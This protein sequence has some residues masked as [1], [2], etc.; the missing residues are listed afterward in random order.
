MSCTKHLP[1][2]H[3]SLHLHF[4]TFLSNFLHKRLDKCISH[5]YSYSAKILNCMIYN[6][7]L[8]KLL[9]NKHGFHHLHSRVILLNS[10]NTRVL[11]EIYVVIFWRAFPF[12]FIQNI[13]ET[14]WRSLFLGTIRE[15]CLY[16]SHTALVA[17]LPL[18]ASG[19]SGSAGRKAGELPRGS[20]PGLGA[21]VW[22]LGAGAGGLGLGLGPGVPWPRR[23]LLPPA[24]ACPWVLPRRRPGKFGRFSSSSDTSEVWGG[25]LVMRSCAKC[26]NRAPKHAA[27]ASLG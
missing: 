3:P 6:M 21:W 15:G 13:H 27:G 16:P 2:S 18:K 12:C 9:A 8:N 11:C 4:P 17:A 10:L 5:R 14:S 20:G 24:A 19:S 25:M 22:G 7:I 1:S 23:P 26:L